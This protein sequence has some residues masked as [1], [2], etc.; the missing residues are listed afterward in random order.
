MRLVAAVMNMSS[1]RDMD[2]IIVPSVGFN[3]FGF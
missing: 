3:I 2:P 1:H